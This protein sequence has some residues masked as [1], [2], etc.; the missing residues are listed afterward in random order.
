MNEDQW[1]AVIGLGLAI[2]LVAVARQLARSQGAALGLSPAQAQALVAI[3]AS[4]VLAG[5]EALQA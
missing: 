1:G 5:Y 3:S 2:G 4:A